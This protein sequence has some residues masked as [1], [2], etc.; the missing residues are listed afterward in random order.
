[1]VYNTRN[2]YPPTK[3]DILKFT[4]EY[5]IFAQYLG[6][7]PIVG[8]L[9]SS[10]FRRDSNPSFGLFY[11]T[12]GALLFKD[13]GTGEAG[14]CFKFVSI[15]ERIKINDVYELLHSQYISKKI[16]FKKTKTIPKRKNDTVD[17]VVEKKE[18]TEEGLNFWYKYGI[19][20]KTLEYFN[21]S[22]ASKYWVNGK[23]H[24]YSTE[25]N[26]IF[27]YEVYEK[28]KIYRPFNKNKFYTNCSNI[29]IQ[30]WEQLDYSK[31]TVIITKS[32]KDVML[33]YEMGF[34]AI[35]P[36]GEGHSIPEKVLKILR[37][38]FKYIIIW[39]DKDLAGIKSTK[40]LLKTQIPDAGFCFTYSKK[41]KDLSDYFLKYGHDKTSLLISNKLNYVKSRQYKQN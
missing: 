13:L 7:R 27:N 19:S 3:K 28:N 32:L 17:I 36:N 15:I 33:L 31:D 18:F 40:K 35:A 11:A 30:G 4:T 25:K 6:F 23:L 9:Y 16:V 22:E 10:P 8:H 39:Y 26:P 1:M 41:E 29:D 24:G 21:V 12:N 14:N 38:N 20:K 34:T 2:L 5:D 37:E